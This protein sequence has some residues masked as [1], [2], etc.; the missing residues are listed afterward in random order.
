MAI[1][2]KPVPEGYHTVTPQ[3]TIANCA[4]AID[5]YKTA[6][7]A[8]DMGRATG[9]DGAIMH[10]EIRIGESRIMVNDP[11]MG[12]RDP[13]ALG[14]SPASLWLYVE[15]CDALYNRAIAAGARTHGPMGKLTD[16]FWGDRSGTIEDPYGYIW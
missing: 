15:D 8:E 5:W 6:L 2:K 1:A 4:H 10:A 13:K 16:Q 7:G 12:G 14:G 11:M 3:L 9:P